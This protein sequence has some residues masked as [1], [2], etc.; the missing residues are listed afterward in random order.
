MSLRLI[1]K[2]LNTVNV[3]FAFGKFLGMID[4]PM[5]EPGDIKSIVRPEMVAVNNALRPYFPAPPR[6]RRPFLTPPK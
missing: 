4:S 5:C 2:V 3:I 1:P 6:P